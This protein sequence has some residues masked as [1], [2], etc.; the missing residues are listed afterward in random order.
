MGVRICLIRYR[1][2]APANNPT[3]SIVTNSVRRYRTDLQA[4]SGWRRW[5][6]WYRASVEL[7]KTIWN[8]SWNLIYNKLARGRRTIC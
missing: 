8:G 3:L 2:T 1:H 6:R 4:L 5:Y 7:K